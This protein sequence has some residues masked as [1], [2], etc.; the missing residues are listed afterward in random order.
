VG[1]LIYFIHHVSV[2][3]QANEIV[4]RVGKELIA[5]IDDLYPENMGGE[6]P[7]VPKGPP[8][9]GLLDA[10]AREGRPV[11]AAEDGYIQFIDGDELVDLAAE[12][13]VIIRVERGPGHYVV[14]TCPLVLV[15]P[16]K[17]SSEQLAEK[18]NSMFALGYQRTSGQD[19]GFLV[20]QL[21]EIAV[22]ALS[23]GV[24]DPFTA[25]VCLDNIGSAL[26]RLVQ[27]DMPSPFR[28][29]AQD[30]LRVITPV[31]TF[32]DL[33]DAAFNPIRQYG[34]SSAAVTNRLLDTIALVARFAHRPADRATL[35]RHAEMITRGAGEG[36]PEAQDRRAVEERCL[37]VRQLCSEPAGSGR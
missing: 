7:Q 2:S 29:D 21:V 11:G 3:I 32:S 12:N 27:R 28:Y 14:A 1:V 26:C 17:R 33:T 24:N 36:L 15:W 5:G 37:A 8:D 13:D 34:R 4:S 10:L 20:D 35:L 9:A 19:L 16:G 18:V 25:T 23:T 30:Q 6:V 31:V 22:R